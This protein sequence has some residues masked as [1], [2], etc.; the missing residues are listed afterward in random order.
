MI[1]QTNLTAQLQHPTVTEHHVKTALLAQLHGRYTPTPNPLEYLPIVDQALSDTPLL[2][3][4]GRS[5]ALGE[6]LISLITCELK[7]HREAMGISTILSEISINEAS[8]AIIRDAQ[9]SNPE[10]IGW[11]WLYYRYVRVDLH[12]HAKEFSQ[13]CAIHERTLRRYQTRT[14]TRLANMLIKYERQIRVEYSTLNL[15][16]VQ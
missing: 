4:H 9:T 13:L 16:D 10:L 1:R 2:S 11:S 6:I 7:K 14:L 15:I 3:I 8:Q 5:I 12:I